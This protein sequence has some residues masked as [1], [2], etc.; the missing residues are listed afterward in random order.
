MR[1]TKTIY[2][3]TLNIVG[4]SKSVLSVTASRDYKLEQR[5]IYEDL[6]T[7]GQTDRLQLLSMLQHEDMCRQSSIMRIDKSKNKII[8]VYRQHLHALII[9][10]NSNIFSA[11]II[12]VGVDI[13]CGLDKFLYSLAQLGENVHNN[14]RY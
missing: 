5:D 3:V 2:T 1:I 12:I 14:D 8:S 11:I 6:Q 4:P 7:D 9:Q 10:F 13:F